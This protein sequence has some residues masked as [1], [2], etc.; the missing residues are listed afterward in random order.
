MKKFP[1]IAWMAL[2]TVAL[3]QL[4][5][6]A[7]PML[8][9]QWSIDVKPVF[10]EG[11]AASTNAETIKAMQEVMRENKFCMSKQF[12][13]AQPYTS[14][15]HF[16][17]L[18]SRQQKS[19]HI[20]QHSKGMGTAAW[21]M[22]CETNDGSTLTEQT[23]ATVTATTLR[24]RGSKRLEKDGQTI[25]AAEVEILGKRIGSKCGADDFNLMQ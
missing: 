23:S 5:A 14:P 10:R 20:A 21:T 24:Q 4:P 22:I 7:Q 11:E 17:K 25:S 1:L 18:R 8:P 9:G 16:L 19:C 2:A 13:A 15:D 3:H 6:G 12:L